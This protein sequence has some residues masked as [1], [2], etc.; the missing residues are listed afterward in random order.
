LFSASIFIQAAM[1]SE[2][3]RRVQTI[4]QKKEGIP[5]KSQNN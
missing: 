3:E 2:E 4:E 1:K 5:K